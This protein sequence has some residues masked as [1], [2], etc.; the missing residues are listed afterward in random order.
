M[1][2]PEY[3]NQVQGQALVRQVLHPEVLGAAEAAVVEEL[4]EDG[5]IG[6]RQIFQQTMLTVG[7][8]KVKYA[9]K[10]LAN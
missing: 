8:G 6:L 9:H 2:F 10:L 7:I 1:L 4:E 3:L 5:D